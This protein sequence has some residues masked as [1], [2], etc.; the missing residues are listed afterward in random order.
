YP[1]RM[2]NFARLAKENGIHSL[3]TSTPPQSPVAWSNFI[4]GL[5]PGGHGI[6]E[7]FHRDP[8]HRTPV[9]ATVKS[10]PSGEIDILWTKYKLPTGGATTTNR[11]GKAFWTILA[12]H[13]V[14]ADIWRMPANFPVEPAKGVSF[15]GMMTPAIDSAYGECTLY[16]TNPSAER[17][18][19][20][21]VVVL[22]D[23]EGVIDTRLSGPTNAFKK[24]DSVT[25]V[26]MK[27]FVDHDAKAAVLEVGGQK[28]VLEPGEWSDFVP[29]TFDLLPGW[30]AV[31]GR[32]INGIV[33]FYLRSVEPEVELYASPVNIDPSAPVAPVS[34]P[35]SASAALADRASGGVGNYYTQGMPEDVNAL[36]REVITVPEFMQQAKLVQNEGERILDYAVDHYL[37]KKDG[38]FLFFYFSG[39]DLCS[40]MMWRH[41]D[42]QHPFHDEKI[43]AA[44]SSAWSQRKGSTWKDTIYDLYMEMDPVVGRLREKL[45]DDTTLIVMSDHG[46]ASYARKFNLNTWLYDNGYL[47]LREGYK[48]EL[49]Q[50]DPAHVDVSIGEYTPKPDD[51]PKGN[52]WPPRTIVDWS[53]TRAYNIGFNAVFLNLEQREQ[54]DPATA[55]SEAGIVKPEQ[56]D[57]LLAEIK[58]KLESYVDQKTNKRPV[59]RCDLAKDVY[60]GSRVKEAPDMIVGFDVGYGNSDEGA[61]GRI[62]DSVLTDNDHAG[63]FNGSHL[64]APDVVH[65]TLMCNRPIASG[66]HG[67]EDITV[68]VLRQFGIAPADGMHGRPVLE[69]HSN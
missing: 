11:T 61:V 55:E 29:V 1:D 13:G 10:D 67:L 9:P 17:A 39:V 46:F 41:F 16:T 25:T 15:S 35:S 21:R 5:N 27:I 19:D 36:K 51:W 38:G 69:T 48:K 49:A 20:K 68:E 60:S 43:A 52:A 28:L 4:T 62:T 65:G 6:F 53:K 32:S 50:D 23:F 63:T 7:F 57:A 59:L 37:A 42:A 40:H 12:E 8:M 3:G 34:E 64:M 24:D 56:A 22:S 14:P 18:G 45:G 30:V 26:E 54:D 2:R 66:E 47:V 58:A 31:P 44:D 33:R